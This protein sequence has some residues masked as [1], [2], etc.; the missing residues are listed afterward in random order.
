MQ[1]RRGEN[2]DGF[3]TYVISDR[4]YAGISTLLSTLD[5]DQ[6]DSFAYFL[7]DQN[8]IKRHMKTN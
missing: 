4:E 6:T 3:E 8:I 5:T 7:E 1:I 2:I